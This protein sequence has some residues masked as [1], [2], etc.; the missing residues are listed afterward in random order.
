MKLNDVIKK[1]FDDGY[2][3][4]PLLT[5]IPQK[6]LEKYTQE[7]DMDISLQKYEEEIKMACR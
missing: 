3:T 6:M 4:Y 7:I 5:D 1:L 2:E